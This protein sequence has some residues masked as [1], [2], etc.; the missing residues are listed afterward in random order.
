[1]PL[2][3]AMACFAPV[4]AAY[5]ASKFW[6]YRFDMLPMKSRVG[7]HSRDGGIDLR[8]QCRVLRLQINEWDVHDEIGMWRLEWVDPAQ[9]PRGISG[10]DAW[11]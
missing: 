10:V 11:H 6:T 5:S 9:H 8:L 1:V 4:Y 2:A 3:Q 7:D